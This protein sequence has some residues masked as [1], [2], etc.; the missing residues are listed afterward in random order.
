MT[1]NTI[2]E[3]KDSREGISSKIQT[4]KWT[5]KLEDKIVEITEEQTKEKE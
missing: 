3:I 2:T 4:E 5:S 1:K